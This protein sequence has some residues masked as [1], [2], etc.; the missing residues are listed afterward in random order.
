MWI[1]NTHAAATRFDIFVPFPLHQSFFFQQG[2]QRT[3]SNAFTFLSSKQLF[4]VL[5]FRR[6]DAAQTQIRSLGG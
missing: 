3:T 1:I 5:F 4:F 6:L 2:L